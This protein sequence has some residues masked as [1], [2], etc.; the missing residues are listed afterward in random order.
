M[1]NCIVWRTSAYCFCRGNLWILNLNNYEWEIK[2]VSDPIGTIFEPTNADDLLVLEDETEGI[3]ALTRFTS[4]ESQEIEVTRYRLSPTDP[5]ETYLL[6][7]MRDRVK[8]LLSDVESVKEMNAL[9]DNLLKETDAIDLFHE[10]VRGFQWLLVLYSHMVNEK[11]FDRKFFA[12]LAGALRAIDEMEFAR[13]D[14][15][16]RR[17]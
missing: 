4:D 5:E 14:Q 13:N 16:R 7:T 10:V 12:E 2:C 11:K 3:L 15:Y 1:T 17:C 8:S 6:P 9:T